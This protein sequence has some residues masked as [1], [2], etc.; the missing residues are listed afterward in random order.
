[1]RVLSRQEFLK[2][3]AGVHA[4]REL[5]SMV[6][7]SHYDTGGSYDPNHGKGLTFMDRHLEYLMK[8]PYV[9]TEAY[10]SNL[11]IMTRAGR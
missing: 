8:H 4:R 7:S 11:R 9:R 2:T 10:L 6:I 5:R 3:S 1:M